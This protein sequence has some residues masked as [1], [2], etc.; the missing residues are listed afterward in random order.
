MIRR[1]PRS[2][3]FPYTTLFRSV[4]IAILHQDFKYFARLV[5]EKTV[6]RQYHRGSSAGLESIHYVL[7]E[8]E[9]LVAGFD[10]EVVAVRGLV[11]AS[12]AEWRIGEYNIV[13][14]AAIWF[15]ERVAQIDVRLYAMQVK[16]HERKAAR[17]RHEILA[18]VCGGAD[19]TRL[20]AVECS[21]TSIHEPLVRTNEKTSSAARRVINGEVLF[22]A[23]VGFH[24][25]AHRL[26]ERARR[27]ILPGTFL[28]FACGFL[29]KSLE[30]RSFYV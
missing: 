15:I 24:N 11:C 4:Q 19:S 28:S 13:A 1:P 16:I 23:R 20:G 22:S 25:P 8:I 30:S 27:E 17:A 14:L 9:L 21:L 18:I 10:G 5:F 3:L 12:S 7:D 6:V 2:T 29:Q 26:N